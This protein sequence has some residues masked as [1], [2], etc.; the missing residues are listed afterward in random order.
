MPTA[1]EKERAYWKQR[2][3]DNAARVHDEV[4]KATE[5]L[6]QTWAEVMKDLQNDIE[7]EYS[8]FASE[9]GLTMADAKKLMTTKELAGLKLSLRKFEELAKANANGQWE[10]ELSAASSRV[11]IS[12]LEAMQLQIRNYLWEAYQD[13]ENAAA[14]ALR[15]AYTSAYYHNIYETQRAAGK[16]SP[17]EEIP[18]GD[19][20]AILYH[21]WAADGR[22]WSDRIWSNREQVTAAA[23]GELL[24]SIIQGKGPVEASERLAQKMGV[25][26]YQ[27]VRLIQTETTYITT[28]ANTAAFKASGVDRVE[29]VATLEAHTC[30]T[31]GALDG[32]VLSLKDVAAG[33]TAPPMHPNCRCVLVPYFDDNKTRRWMKDP[34]TFERKTVA[35]TT[36]REW[37]DKYIGG[38]KIKGMDTTAFWRYD[39]VKTRESIDQKKKQLSQILNK[40]YY[41]IWKDPVTPADWESKKSA[42]P[43]KMDYFNDQISQG[44]EVTK[45][46]GLIND[47][48]DFEKQGQTYSQL[49]TDIS[50]LQKRVD[51][52]LQKLG[53][54]VSNKNDAFSDARK[55][56]ALNFGNNEK[57]A[58]DKIYRPVASQAWLKSTPEERLAG[59]YYTAGSGAYNRPLSGFRKPYY[60]ASDSG[61]EEKYYKGPNK[62]WIN[63]EGSGEDIRGLT[64]MIERS[65]YK[66]DIWLRRGCDYGAMDSFF[67]LTRGTIQQMTDAQLNKLVGTQAKINSFV[68]C[69][70]TGKGTAGFNGQVNLRIY[71]PAGTEMLY[72]EPFSEYG[73]GS[74]R[75]W[76][77]K[78]GQSDFGFEF[79]MLI[80]RGAEYWCTSIQRSGS[81]LYIELEVHPEKGYN[82]FQQDDK[83]WKGP[84]D[85][86]K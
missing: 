83:D 26:Q 85:M 47:L 3:I 21:P 74:K 37:F 68:S 36:Y 60:P 70:G 31:C 14:A 82:K 63:Y 28:A 13:T 76:D 61:W 29:Y 49:E 5:E 30:E 4:D 8:R 15:D 2:Y 17:M 62:V 24:R 73:R 78:K 84:R 54:K 72:C 32:K 45:F 51:N 1:E 39:L 57:A 55:K 58:A 42:I 6:R 50:D 22:E 64:R 18:A 11:R 10:K 77:G 33:M 20:D 46:E 86:Y 41:N 53:A 23:Q 16:F 81:Q 52:L 75:Y 38:K 7:A 35:N 9:Q 79:E 43:K 66:Q 44:N 67:N 65:K 34:D 48:K 80:Q 40:Q 25:G 69:G 27:A 71:C 12:R 56:S 59:Y 19:I